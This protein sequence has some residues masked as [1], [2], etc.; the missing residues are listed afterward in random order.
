MNS[1]NQ[2]P[3]FEDYFHYADQVDDYGYYANL[4]TNSSI[5]WVQKNIHPFVPR[6]QKDTDRD[7]FRNMV[8][9]AQA[10]NF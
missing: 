7:Y 5:E 8:L 3:E 4:I 10:K 9:Y 2:P 1:N 6:T